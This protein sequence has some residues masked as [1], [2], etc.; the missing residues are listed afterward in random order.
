VSVQSEKAASLLQVQ[1]TARLRCQTP[2]VVFLRGESGV[3]RDQYKSI[4]QFV[5]AGGKLIYA[6]PI[7]YD[8]N[9]RELIQAGVFEQCDVVAWTPT[10]EWTDQGIAFRQID[11][12]RA[13]VLIQNS[14]DV[15][16][17][18]KIRSRGRTSR[19]GDTDLQ[20]VLALVKRE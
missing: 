12:V 11:P 9:E 13:T 4:T 20:I 19:F 17:E 3:V 15:T 14:D 16:L 5:Q 10:K 7:I 18:Y 6:W 8:P 1:R 2:L